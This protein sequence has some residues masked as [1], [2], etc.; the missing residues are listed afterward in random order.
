M[1]SNCTYICTYVCMDEHVYTGTYV[2][3]YAY[4]HMTSEVDIRMH[5]HIFAVSLVLKWTPVNHLQ[6]FKST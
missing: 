4:F 3:I 2:H 1:R 5:V 6:I